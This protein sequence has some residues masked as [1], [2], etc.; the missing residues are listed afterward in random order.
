M[1]QYCLLILIQDE[2]HNVVGHLS[3]NLDA[4]SSSHAIS[5]A[6]EALRKVVQLRYGDNH[7]LYGFQVVSASEDYSY[8][9]FRD[10]TK[11]RIVFTTPV[12]E[13]KSTWTQ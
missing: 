10:N 13:E 2:H 9:E 5:I 8:Y 1:A 4:E 7:R 6:L 12:E 11:P 3:G